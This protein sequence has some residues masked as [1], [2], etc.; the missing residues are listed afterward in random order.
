MW[1]RRMW[2]LLAS[3]V[4]LALFITMGT[5]FTSAP[6]RVEATGVEDLGVFSSPVIAPI[7]V[8]TPAYAFIDSERRHVVF[9]TPGNRSFVADIRS[10]EDLEF[11]VHTY[12]ILGTVTSAD[13]DRL[14]GASYLALGSDMGEVL[15]VNVSSFQPIFRYVQGYATPV[16]R[17][18]VADRK[19]LALFGSSP[20]RVRIFD[21]DRG[22]WVELGDVVPTAVR[23]PMQGY[24]VSDADMLTELTGR[25]R[26]SRP[27]A[28]VAFTAI[29]D[30]GIRLVVVNGTTNEP[31]AGATV[32]AYIE[33]QAAFSTMAT[34]DRNGTALLFSSAPILSAAFYVKIGRVCYRRHFEELN[35]KTPGRI[36]ELPVPLRVS[37]E[38]IAPCPTYTVS[39][40]I[41]VLDLTS[42]TPSRLARIAV[43]STHQRV[44]ILGFLEVPEGRNFKYLLVLGGYFTDLVPGY[45]IRFY[46]LDNKFRIVDDNSTWYPV[47]GA[48]TSFSYSDDGDAIV[49]GTSA[50]V[51]HV[52]LYSKSRGRYVLLWSYRLPGAVR[53]IAVS[54]TVGNATTV[55][56][57]VAADSSGNTQ[58]LLLNDTV[59]KPLFRIDEALFFSTGAGTVAATSTDLDIV[60]LSSAGGVYL[61]LGVGSTA[62]KH[63]P[64]NPE[65][66]VLIPA[67]IL[68][69]DPRGEPISGAVVELVAPGTGRVVV[70]NTTDISGKLEVKYLKPGE[71]LLKVFTGR[72]YLEDITIPIHVS[73]DSP[74][75][76]VSAEYRP[77][78]VIIRFVDA[79]TK[80]RIAEPVLLR[81]NG[82]EI[83]IEPE[84]PEAV[85]KLL[86][87][88]YTLSVEPIATLGE[89][90]LY[91]P[92]TLSF[93]VPLN[94]SITVELTRR[95]L[96]V[97][98][99]IVD[100][101]AH[102]PLRESFRV[103]VTD[104]RGE[105]I[106][107][108]TYQPGTR[109]VLFTV[110]GKGLLNVS[111][112]PVA[113][114]GEEPGYGSIGRV[115]NVTKSGRFT[116]EVPRRYIEL[117]LTVV[118]ERT[119]ASPLLPIDVVVDGVVEETIQPN[120]SGT[121]LQLNKG[122]HVIRL[123]PRAE[124]GRGKEVL[125]STKEL[126]IDLVRST[127]LTVVLERAYVRLNIEAVDSL[128][129]RTPMGIVEVYL[130][131][132]KLG[133]LSGG[134]FSGYVPVGHGVLR[135]HSVN[136]IYN[137]YSTKL[138][139]MDDTSLN[140]TLVRKLHTVTVT[141]VSD[142][143]ERLNGATVIAEGVGIPFTSSSVSVDGVAI[144]KIPYGMFKICAEMPGYHPRCIDM[145]VKVGSAGVTIILRPQIL[146][147]IMRYL[148]VL[149]GV[150]VL[151]AILAVI[152]RYR[153]KLM[154]LIAPEE[155]VI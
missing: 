21:L 97:S 90:P 84:K 147:I 10:L 142:L 16:V 26:S 40:H 74:K 56:G 69:L 110:Y 122:M 4:L 9:V 81:L 154:A 96:T 6:P 73:R 113:P 99:E 1:S 29:G 145:V 149:V 109:T 112:L 152:F 12:P 50:G 103:V 62:L 49:V 153:S 107:N 150:G 83:V 121:T 48:V 115:I 3:I 87:G 43:E 54:N 46:Y 119:G 37:R 126:R 34:T 22:G 98:L 33:N 55:R 70:R 102:S 61:C 136:G 41:D 95:N 38:A 52:F 7:D 68:V 71:Y 124:D 146:T 148:P 117:N 143:G 155:E 76:V 137:D 47:E 82:E 132:T 64:L 63:A 139:L 120:E 31:I 104:S 24:L 66:H 27:I 75:I 94:R 116:I 151:A 44:D 18:R 93:A 138:K 133:D 101:L 39:M 79:Y 134:T 2:R 128:T 123:V 23:I 32:F 140:V 127:N 125:Y 25:G 11:R 53:S 108:N 91:N 45:L 100:K 85:V 72:G 17:I 80:R 86:P 5:P 129:R 130:N 13:V 88:N 60:V 28:A 20:P 8:P 144:L 42:D 105:V 106:L 14:P 51:I 77:V 19:V 89:E 78:E 114:P 57:V 59:M 67:E 58:I 30:T 92:A 65:D 135:L 131:D 36:Y 15:V 111:V 141:V 35:F 118:D